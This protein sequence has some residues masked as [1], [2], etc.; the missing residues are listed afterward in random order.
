MLAC[1][2]VGVAL[3]GGDYKTPQDGM[4]YINE[5]AKR[6]VV[7]RE[8]AKLYSDEGIVGNA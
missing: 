8:H 1:N 7:A 6:V 5:G 4:W 2:Q 3:N